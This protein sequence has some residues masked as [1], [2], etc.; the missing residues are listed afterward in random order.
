[1]KKMLLGIGVVAVTVFLA[2]PVFAGRSIRERLKNTLFGGGQPSFFTVDGQPLLS[3]D[4]N[5]QR[6]GQPLL[7]IGS[8]GSVV[9]KAM[10]DEILSESSVVPVPSGSAGFSYAYNPDLNIFERQAIGL[11][12]IFTERVQTLGKGVLAVGATY[13]RQDFDTFN[14]EDISRLRIRPGF[15]SRER[16]PLGPLIENND[17]EAILDLD[18][19]TNTAALYAIYGVTDWL[20]VSVLLPVTEIHVRARSTIRQANP[21]L[22]GD[23]P[24]FR[25]DR[26]CTVARAASNQCRIADFILL[27]RGTPFGI[28]DPR[29]GQQVGEFTDSVTETRTGIGDVI[30]RGKARF[31]EGEWG[32]FGGLTEITL[33]TGSEHDFLGDNAFKARFF[34]MYAKGI[35][36]NR[37]NLYFNGGGKVTTQNSH[38]NTL[39]Y[40]IATDLRA[41]DWLSL[42]AEV[43]EVWRV[44]AGGL[45][46]TFLDGSFG[47][48]V[49]PWKGLL[50]HAA[51]RI[52]ASDDGLRS[53]LVYLAGVEYDF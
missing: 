12:A 50:L 34:L 41:T 38:K 19:E 26:N 39:E 4:P 9:A 42:V 5:R 24:A 31:A 36:D 1:M 48:K 10:G 28:N 30:I 2:H 23:I 8:V 53:D 46:D 3:V 27:R 15:F 25:A 17:V 51:F 6:F 49:N 29:S 20:D 14:G 18:V 45:P 44:N 52:P 33:P 32:A 43:S 21:V 7:A 47:F 22:Q 16:A 35:F 40:N 13:I 11:G 37:L